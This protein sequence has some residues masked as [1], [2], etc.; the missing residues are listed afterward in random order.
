M[1][2]W[3]DE[4]VKTKAK[5]GVGD[6]LF[7][8]KEGFV[9]HDYVTAVYHNGFGQFYYTFSQEV[10]SMQRLPLVTWYPEWLVYRTKAAL[11]KS[12]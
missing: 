1:A 12:L 4:Y 2:R 10:E 5:Y 7:Y 9:Y 8:I 11:I 3:D 6:K